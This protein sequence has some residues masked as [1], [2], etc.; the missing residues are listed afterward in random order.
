MNTAFF[1]N[2]TYTKTIARKISCKTNLQFVVDTGR[3]GGDFSF[4]QEIEE[5]AKCRYD[6]PDIKAGNRPMWGFKPTKER[7]KIYNNYYMKLSASL[8]GLDIACASG[9]SLER[10]SSH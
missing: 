2:M 3:N 4:G 7:A 9:W 1:A 8:A 5:M 6:P 10:P